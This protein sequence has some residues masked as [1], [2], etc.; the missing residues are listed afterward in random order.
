[1]SKEICRWGIMG[2]ATIAQKNWQAIQNSGNGTV[3]AVASRSPA[4]AAAF[5]SERQKECPF[6]QPPQGCS[7]DELLSRDDVDAVYLP[8]PT[9]LRK[10]WVTKAARAG[11]H[12]LCEKPCAANASD[13]REM[14]DVCREHNVQ[15]M[16]G[17]MFM[18][19]QRLPAVRRVLNDP[20]NIGT[21]RRIQSHF[22]FMG[23]ENFLQNNIRVSSELEPHGCVGDLG[24]Y[25]IRMALWIMN[26]QMPLEVSA[27]LLA[28]RV[29]PT[30]VQSVPLELTA[31]LRF[32]GNVTAGFY[33]SFLCDQQQTITISGTKGSLV[34]NDFVLPYSGNEAAFQ[35][36]K[37][38][39][40]V[41]GCR[42][43]MV[44]A[45]RRISVREIS[46]NDPTAQESNLF[47]N[48]G[49]LVL[50][51]DTNSYWGD[52]ALKTQVVLDACLKSAR[53]DSQLVVPES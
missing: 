34:I 36:V 41:S 10:N 17:V 45:E 9:G 43:E 48:F 14:L 21:V 35:I 7:Y 25:C 15:F 52:I 19:S 27:R 1:M 44:H 31:E 47:R 16:D 20:D 53:N 8:I 2:T 13:L 12:V 18:H 39:F 11:K 3:V 28:E 32:P 5:I 42:F 30:G 51:H 4:R 37:N 49:D 6:Q 40:Q 22:S 33:C 29:D 38:D 50:S 24:W 26:D 23:E 46:N